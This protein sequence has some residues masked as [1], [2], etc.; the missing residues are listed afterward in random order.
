MTSH[1]RKSIRRRGACAKWALLARKKPAPRPITPACAASTTGPPRAGTGP[2]PHRAGAAIGAAPRPRPDRKAAL[3][4]A[5]FAPRIR[6]AASPAPNILRSF[7]FITEH[8]ASRN[9]SF[10]ERVDPNIIPQSWQR[11]GSGAIAE[12]AAQA[13]PHE[14]TEGESDWSEVYQISGGIIWKCGSTR[15]TYYFQRVNLP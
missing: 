11:Y 14:P 8:P 5:P 3:D 12:A 1:V 7:P 2:A 6:A 9:E 15:A 10:L 4:D 13:C